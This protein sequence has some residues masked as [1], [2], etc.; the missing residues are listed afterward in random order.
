MPNWCFNKVIVTGPAE[1][2]DR[3]KQTCIRPIQNEDEDDDVTFDFD[4]V[5]PMPSII[6]GTVSGGYVDAAVLVLGRPDAVHHPFLAS[7]MREAG[8]QD[9]EAF[10]TKLGEKT[11]EDVRRSI[12]APSLEERMRQA[13][14]QDIEAFKTKLGEKTFEDVRRSLQALLP[15][16]EERMRQAGVQ[17]IEAFKAKL[18]EKTFEDA[19]CSI[20]AFD[21]TGFSNWYD[22]SITNWGTK[23]NS[24][25]F[26]VRAEEPG[27]YEFTF[28]SAWSPPIPVFEKMGK[29]FP[30][31]D[32]DLEMCEP[33]MEFAGE[34]TIRA[35]TMVFREVPFEDSEE[36]A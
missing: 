4:T 30:T 1:A 26:D 23:W 12:Q 24:S 14:V 21:E 8:V 22:W 16:L 27:R 5:I 33:G 6:I 25:D 28:Y 7:L 15:S 3:F 17:D 29:M 20:Q 31:L 32:F 10:K 19:R 35:G 9:I 2:I 18:G 34:G 13:G 11:F 36:V